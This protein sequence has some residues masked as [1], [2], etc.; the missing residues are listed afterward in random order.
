VIDDTVVHEQPRDP[1]PDQEFEERPP[2]VRETEAR[3]RTPRSSLH[4]A[5]VASLL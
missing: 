3:R 1:E 5:A 4:E 2:A